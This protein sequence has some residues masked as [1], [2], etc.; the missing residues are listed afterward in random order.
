M[1][2]AQEFERFKQKSLLAVEKE[3]SLQTASPVALAW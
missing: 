2:V 3:F 1:L